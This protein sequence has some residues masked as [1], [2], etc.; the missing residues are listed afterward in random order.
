MSTDSGTSVNPG[1]DAPKRARRLQTGVRSL[2]ALVAC[3]AAVLWAWRYLSE[4][5]DPM[6]RENRSIQE[7]A[8]GALR[9]GGPAE[10]LAAIVELQRVDFA[11]NSIAIPALIRAL[12]D[13]E[14]QVR[15]ASAQA[16]ASIG[17]GVAKSRSGGGIIRD[18][19]PVLIRCLKDPE[20]SVRSA[21][22][23]SLGEI[24]AL[25]LPAGA[26]PPINRGSVK[27]ELI[28]MLGDR[29]AG[30]R[31]AAIRTVA[32][33]RPE[34]GPPEAL[35][36]ALKDD[37]AENRVAAIQGLSF[38]RQGLDPWVPILLRLA[39]HDLDPSVRE[40]CFTTL[41][42]AFTPP[43][44]TAAAVPA[45]IASLKSANVKV[46]SQAASILGTV[47]A[48]ANAAVPE[49]LRVLNGPLAPGVGPFYGPDRILDPGCA[50]AS[51]LGRIAPGSVEAKRVMAALT[52]VARSGPVIRRGWAAYALGE[53]GPAADEAVPVLIKVIKES[54]PE[55][56]TENEASAAAAL[57]KIAPDTPSADQAVAA[58]LP[59]LESK[60]R[61][62]RITAIKALGRFG[63]RAAVAVPKIRA[64][65]GDPD[66]EVRNAAAKSLPAI[67]TASAP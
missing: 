67:D 66:A 60:V 5:S 50:A 15:V 36:A 46:R 24:A 12:E 39:E 52:E 14:T 42:Y 23:V 4:N 57:G 33:H 41:G 59:V 64:L 1:T 63:P 32:P 7:R 61:F 37:S 10:R 3:C 49:L 35:A 13:P 51:A 62:S 17:P 56:R 9:S 27:D 58:L 53:F 21:A 19:V 25:R 44:V 31:L 30:V 38:V 16:L 28:A 54:T 2:I 34:N 45:L 48:V 55:P 22:T 65:K 40:Q 43:A 29:D 6:R 47:K 20:P 11:D 26:N 8:I 18:A